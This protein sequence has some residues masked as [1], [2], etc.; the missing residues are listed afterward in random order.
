MKL[1][2]RLPVFIDDDKYI[3]NINGDEV[4]HNFECNDVGADTR[5]VLHPALPSEDVVVVATG[6]CFDFNKL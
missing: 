6:R 5:M 1:F 3:W 2:F 4:I